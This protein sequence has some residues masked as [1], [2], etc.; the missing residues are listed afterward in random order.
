M[1]EKWKEE[2]K[3]KSFPALRIEYLYNGNVSETL[4]FLK[5][6]QTEWEIGDFAQRES[7]Q[8]SPS[9]QPQ[10]LALDS[11]KGQLFLQNVVETILQDDDFIRRVSENVRELSLTDNLSDNNEKVSTPLMREDLAVPITMET[12][13]SI[14]KQDADGVL[15]RPQEIEPE[16]PELKSPELVPHLS[17]S[18]RQHMEK[19]IEAYN[20]PDNALREH[21]K[22][23][24]E[25]EEAWGQRPKPFKD[26]EFAQQL[27]LIISGNGR[28]RAIHD[29]GNY[30]FLVPIKGIEF[31]SE[32]ILKYGYEQFFE[33]DSLESFTGAQSSIKL[34]RPAILEKRNDR[35]YLVERGRV[36]L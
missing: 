21:M 5:K 34:I 26:L 15:H 16:P 4:D 28:F 3:V 7:S 22:L 9:P 8:A 31:T 29:E 23:V 17:E 25:N 11:K 14:L 6:I 20:N 24:L 33:W 18:R 27:P 12:D 35:Y 13:A 36:E 1:F 2:K 19:V 30:Y 10:T 32:S